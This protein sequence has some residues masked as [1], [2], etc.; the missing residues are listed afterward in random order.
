MAEYLDFSSSNK[1]QLNDTN[2]LFNKTKISPEIAS[3]SSM[4][5][6]FFLSY[7]MS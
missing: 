1:Q 3:M 7:I 2:L 6:M 4:S 5:S